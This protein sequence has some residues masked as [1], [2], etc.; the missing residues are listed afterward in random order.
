[1]WR[2]S[3]NSGAAVCVA[4]DLAYPS[5]LLLHD[6]RIAVSEAG[7]HRLLDF[8]TLERQAPRILL[9]DLPGCPGRLSLA[10]GGGAWVAV[11]APRAPSGLIGLALRLDRDFT[12]TR[13]LHGRADGKC[14]G[15]SSCLEVRGEL[16]VTCKG[17]NVVVSAD[18]TGEGPVS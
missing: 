3:L 9:D 12:P 8:P 5:G 14:H 16:I 2:I 17:G 7:R 10:P 11:F 13:S 6:G 18:L 15:V 4:S 1:V